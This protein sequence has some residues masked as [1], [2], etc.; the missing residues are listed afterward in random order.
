M[1]KQS[2]KAGEVVHNALSGEG[3]I[4]GEWGDLVDIDERG[5][6][7]AI[8]GAGVYDVQFKSGEVRSVNLCWLSRWQ[9]QAKS[10]AK[11]VWQLTS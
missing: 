5:I 1:V 10:G 6:E 9:R 3:I 7:L 2:F 8:H 11:P 4:L